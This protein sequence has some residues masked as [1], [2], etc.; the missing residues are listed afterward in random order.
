MGGEGRRRW[1][2]SYGMEVFLGR[3]VVGDRENAP[4][5]LPNNPAGQACGG[6]QGCQGHELAS[7]LA[8][9]NPGAVWPPSTALAVNQGL[10]V[11]V[12]KLFALMLVQHPP[13]SLAPPLPSLLPRLSSLLLFTSSLLLPPPLY[14]FPLLPALVRPQLLRLLCSAF[15]S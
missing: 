11:A 1:Q 15:Y 13:S 4:T 7:R 10:V 2:D 8:E 12:L 9:P 5:K 6:P 14:P 3:V